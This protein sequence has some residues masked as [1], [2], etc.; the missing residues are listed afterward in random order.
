ML[1]LKYLSLAVFAL[2][3]GAIS[4]GERASKIVRANAGA[5]RVANSG[6]IESF[7]L[8][9]ENQAL[10]KRSDFLTERGT[11]IGT[12]KDTVRTFGLAT[13]IG[14]AAVGDPKVLPDK[15][16]A[17][18]RCDDVE[19]LLK[20]FADEVREDLNNIHLALSLADPELQSTPDLKKTQEFINNLARD[21]AKSLIKDLAGG[22]EDGRYREI[23]RPSLTEGGT[24]KV[25]MDRSIF[26]EDKK[27]EFSS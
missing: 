5:N 6:H 14:I 1:L 7:A 27:V 20:E 2:P 16:L 24:L 15:V 9:D 25:L 10:S 17:H 26:A 13:C 18:V 22:D 3:I 19:G 4:I 8:R 21:T 11:I 23:I 12:D